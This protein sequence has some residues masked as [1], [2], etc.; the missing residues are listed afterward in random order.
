M[1]AQIKLAIAHLLPPEMLF[2]L[3]SVKRKLMKE[4]PLPQ[5]VAL[6]VAEPP[7]QGANRILQDIAVERYTNRK[8]SAP[9]L[10][11]SS[12]DI[13]ILP[14]KEIARALTL[15]VS[16]L[17]SVHIVGDIAEF[18]T[19]GGFTARTM[20]AAM[21]FDPVSQPLKDRSVSANLFRRLHLFDSF[22]GLPEITAEVDLVS[23]HVI[24]GSWSKGG[25]K[26]LGASQLREMIEGIIPRSRLVIH[27]GWFADTVKNLPDDTRF[28]MIHFDGDL[29]S[30]T[31][32][33]LAPCFARGFI[34]EGAVLC[35]DDWNCNRAN[36]AFGE[37]R[38]WADLV[39]QFQIVASHCGDYGVNSTKFV[40]HSYRGIPVSE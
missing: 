26:V 33:A 35:F 38:A 31:M 20:A 15:S 18:G 3:R 39:E 40:I 30:S 2:R 28:A 12:D 34:S 16:Y 8:I 13:L 37:R 23:P 1:L 25:C 4:P 27:D 32:D 14:A 22:E 24:S 11:F 19:M 5:Q 21:V 6:P 36:P 29:Y 9:F 7:R 10:F 17:N